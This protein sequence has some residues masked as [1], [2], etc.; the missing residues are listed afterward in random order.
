MKKLAK[1]VAQQDIYGHPIQVN[2]QGDDTYKTYLGAFVT[3]AIYGLIFFN[4]MTLFEAF[5]DGSKQ[6]ENIQTVQFDRWNSSDYNF[7]EQ[8]L[9]ITLMTF[10]PIDE[11]LGKFRMYQTNHCSSTD[12][13][14]CFEDDENSAYEIELVECD[15]ETLL[16]QEEYWFKRLN[17]T[18]DILKSS[19]RCVSNES[20]FVKSEESIDYFS[21]VQLHW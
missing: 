18:Y 17:V 13:E 3:L 1:L 5:R 14:E 10:P 21:T 12:I 11:S 9:K 4:S 19:L 2:Y 20:L 6:S 7:A 8:N 15:E 16:D